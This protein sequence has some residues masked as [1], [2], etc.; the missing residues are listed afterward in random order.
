MRAS[1][2][3]ESIHYILQGQLEQ[4]ELVNMQDHHKR[5]VF[6][7]NLYCYIRKRQEIQNF[8]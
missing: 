3:Q 2:Q 5:R 7:D 8:E 4:Q 1:I 6:K